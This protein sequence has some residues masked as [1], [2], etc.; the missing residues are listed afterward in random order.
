MGGPGIVC[1]YVCMCVRARAR[2]H[3]CRIR[4]S[5]KL[6]SNTSTLCKDMEVN[7][8]KFPGKVEN[9]CFWGIENFEK[10]GD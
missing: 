10:S 8:Q 6:G 5:D 2:A 9:G 3:N 1:V 7:T 4:S